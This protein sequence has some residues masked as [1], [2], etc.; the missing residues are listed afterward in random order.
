M[1]PCLQKGKNLDHHEAK[2]LGL[3]AVTGP[4]ETTQINIFCIVVGVVSLRHSS[5]CASALPEN[6]RVRPRL[7]FTF[8]IVLSLTH[9]RNAETCL[10]R[11]LNCGEFCHDSPTELAELAAARSCDTR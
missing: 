8:S 11:F 5:L 4:W 9:F 2:E 6:C 3:G 1:K 7:P 10:L